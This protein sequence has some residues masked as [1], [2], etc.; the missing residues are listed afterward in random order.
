LLEVSK[1]DVYYDS[2]QALKEVSLDIGEHEIVGLLGPNGHGKTTL[3]K[4]ISGLLKIRSGRIKFNG[5][6]IS[7]RPPYE[8]VEMGI[9]HVPEGGGLFPDMTVMENL[10]LGA[11]TPEAWRKK[12]NNLDKVFQIFPRLEERK[13]QMVWTLSGGERRMVALGRGL[14][15]STKLL[16]LDE[17]SLGLAPKLTQEVYT[18]IKEIKDTGVTILLVEQN[19][20]YISELSEKAYLLEN[21]KIILEGPKEKILED[22]RVK[23]AYLGKK[24]R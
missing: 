19:I 24:Y 10:K 15:A 1:I 23:E 18:K 5:R 7:D 21:G 8:I 14:M 17:P 12:K 4:A 16:M 20:Y 22:K 6:I 13:D 3:L 9:V 11:F 2:Y